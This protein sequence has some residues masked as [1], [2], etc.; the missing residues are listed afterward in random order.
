MHRQGLFASALL[1]AAA[2]VA[3]RAGAADDLST[4]RCRLVS[5]DLPAAFARCGVLSV[6]EDPDAPDGPTV[7]LFVA[8]VAALT[9]TP[10]PDPLL[11]ITGGPGESTV[12]FY[13]QLR[14]AF[15]PVRRD[16]DVILVDQRGTG[17]SADGFRCSV[18]DDLALDTAGPEALE[19]FIPRCLE[20]LEHDARTYTTSVAVRDLERVREALG[21]ERWNVY[22][23]SYGTRVAQHY[24]RRFPERTRAVVLDGVVPPALA[25]GPDVAREAQDALDSIFARCAADE[26]CGSRFTD[27]PT[28]FAALSKRLETEPVE[29]GKNPDGTSSAK[30]GATE[31]KALVRFMSYNGATVA[32]LPVLLHEA[33][34]GNYE[35]LA[36]QTRTVLRGLPEALSFSMSNSVL[37]T[38]DVPFIVAGASDNLAGTYL[39][40]STVDAL[41]RI[42]SLW[43]AGKIDDDFKKPVTSDHPVLLLSGGN[44]PITP[45][46]YAETV[47]ATLANSVHLVGQGQGHGMMPIG[48]VPRIVRAFL[49]DADPQALDSECL[50]VEPPTPFFL[51]LFGPGP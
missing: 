31:L 7:D 33:Y 38:E 6:P 9:A 43:P 24:L 5:G 20:Q 41:D 27:L 16:R 14:G 36:S 34:A 40:T 49:E 17:R 23:V 42:C 8:R 29:T 44:D 11:V 32:L 4:E 13:L 12:D 3:P 26:G 22:G 51:S 35:P 30:F 2:L 19:A 1:A 21:I 10:R 18:P 50:A 37:C 15:E 25:L 45:P 47:A 28:E 48:C 39:G 46:E